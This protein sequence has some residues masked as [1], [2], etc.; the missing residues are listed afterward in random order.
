MSEQPERMATVRSRLN[1]KQLPSGWWHIRGAGPCNYTQ[2]PTWPCSEEEI[3]K[4]AHPEAGDNFLETVCRLA[5]METRISG[6][7]GD[8][9]E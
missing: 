3:R 4:H 5:R 2:P 1:V 9:G 6:E 7:E 8:G